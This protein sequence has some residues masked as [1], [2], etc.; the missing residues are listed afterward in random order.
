MRFNKINKKGK[1]GYLLKAII[2]IIL[3]AILFPSVIIPLAQ[4]LMQMDP[5]HYL[6]GDDFDTDNKENQYLTDL[7]DPCPC[8]SSE[9]ERE[10]DGFKFCVAP[11]YDKGMCLAADKIVNDAKKQN[12][13]KLPGFI[14]A[15]NDDGVYE[16][17]YYYSACMDLI[18]E[19]PYFY[20]REVLNKITRTNDYRNPANGPVTKDKDYPN[21]ADGPIP[22]T[23]DYPNPAK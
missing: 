14:L 17:I 19:D 15:L 7:T 11:N 1:M 13:E 2:F 21:P 6:D 16:C 4:N 3:L 10:V 12:T 20:Q 5:D 22:V 8:D 9:R 18:E 23:G